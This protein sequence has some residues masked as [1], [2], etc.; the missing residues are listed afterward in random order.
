MYIL[1]QSVHESALRAYAPID[2]QRTDAAWIVAKAVNVVLAALSSSTQLSPESLLQTLAH[3][4]HDK[5]MK[6]Y[7]DVIAKEFARF[8]D[9][10][11]CKEHDS[12]NDDNEEQDDEEHTF[13]IFNF[14]TSPDDFAVSNAM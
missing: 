14:G 9:R 13:I 11:Q 5:S 1:R 8:R 2:L 6:D 7:I 12:E 4:A 3:C 10:P